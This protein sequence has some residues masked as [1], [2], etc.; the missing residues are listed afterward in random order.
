VL[1]IDDD[2]AIERFRLVDAIADT[3]GG[4]VA[5]KLIAKVR[6]SGSFGYA[7][8]MPEGA[9]AQNPTVKITRARSLI[10]P[11]CVSWP[12]TC[13]MAS[14][15]CLLVAGCRCAKAAEAH[16]LGEK[17]ALGRSSLAPR[18][19]KPDFFTP[20]NISWTDYKQSGS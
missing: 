4:D 19:H 17:A 11:R 10:H 9:A 3:V 8:V 7:S 18:V 1:A 14:S 6:Q 15:F 20:A 2:K 13:A 12:M 16:V 5:A